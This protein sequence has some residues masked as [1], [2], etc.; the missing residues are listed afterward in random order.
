MGG[1][2]G[3]G[4]SQTTSVQIPAWLEQAAQSNLGRADEL[5]KIGYTPYYGPDVAALTPMQEAAMRNT[6]AGAQ[7]FGMDA[8][9][10]TG[11]PA[12][13]TYAGGVQGYG[14][15]SLYDQAL[16]ELKLRMPGQYA[17]LRAPFIDP[18]T[19]APPAL[20]FSPLVPPPAPPAGNVGMADGTYGRDGGD[21]TRN[22]NDLRVSRVAGGNWGAS[23]PGG[24]N[25]RNPASALNQAVARATTGP[26]RAPTAADRP[27]A[28]P[29][30]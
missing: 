2:G 25:T 11:M 21:R 3:K 26:T 7:A 23:L 20:S 1:G 28:N 9:T 30:R 17:A 5:S 18:V 10:G 4:G 15:G 13:Q 19:G 12:P 22:E 27:K 29:K 24:V 6:N 14:S 8:P 16:G